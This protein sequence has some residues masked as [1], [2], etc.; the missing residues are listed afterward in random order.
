MPRA[1]RSCDPADAVA[2]MRPNDT[3][4]ERI[5]DRMMKVSSTMS[6]PVRLRYS[7]S[8]CP[9]H[10]PIE[11]P[12]KNVL[13]ATSVSPNTRLRNALVHERSSV[14]PVSFVYAA[15]GAWHQK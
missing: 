13:P 9:S 15:F 5:T 12:A 4:V 8:S 11:P 2:N 10:D 6:E 1:E 7:E 3:C 14:M